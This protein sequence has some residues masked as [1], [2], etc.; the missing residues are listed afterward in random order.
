[1]HVF[2]FTV[3]LQNGEGPVHFLGCSL[4]SGT[5]RAPLVF[6]IQDGCG[7]KFVA[8]GSK[9]V[10]RVLVTAV[11][12]D[13]GVERALL[14]FQFETPAG[15]KNTRFTICRKVEAPFYRP[16]PGFESIK[17]Q[18]PYVPPPRH[19]VKPKQVVKGQR[20]MGKGSIARPLPKLHL[21]PALQAG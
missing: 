2:E 15:S 18:A 14:Q 13:V 19:E 16:G 9:E 3:G 7:A 21:A 1:M 17:G 4:H 6:D 5:P 12:R 10:H 20:P 11:S 8:L